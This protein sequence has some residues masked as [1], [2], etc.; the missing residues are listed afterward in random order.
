MALPSGTFTTFSAIGN[1]EDLT[2]AIYNI[3]PTETPFASAVARVKATAVLHEWQ[4]DGLEAATNA[5][6]LE[7]DDADAITAVPTE[8]LSNACQ[9]FRKVVSV[10]RTQRTI[11]SAGRRDE[12]AYQLTKR[13]KELKRN[14]EIA[15]TS[16]RGKSTGS[17]SAAR[18]LGGV[19]T[20]LTKANGSIHLDS[21]ATATTPGGGATVVDGGTP[22]TLTADALEL[23]VE[24]IIGNLWDNG[25][26]AN[27][28]MGGRLFKQTASKM[29]GVATRYR[30]VPKGEEAAIIGG[31]DLYVSNFGEYII[32]PNRFMRTSVAFFLDYDYWAIAELDP[33][34]V[35]PLAKTGDSD[36]AMM[37]CEL[38][39]EC[40]N[41]KAS[42]KL[43]DAVFA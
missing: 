18:Y 36:R 19:E 8:R 30:E 10:S 17:I 2:D 29:T 42:A 22:V 20:W 39:L 34:Q 40:R 9:I 32:V 12:Y 1:R 26:D 15:L 21:G 3:D 37:V 38:S 11:L 43:T 4:T 27:V 16:G 13:G 5:G 41:P 14:I 24:T 33:V 7:G 25:S 31:A 6:F 35:V 23:Y 28:M